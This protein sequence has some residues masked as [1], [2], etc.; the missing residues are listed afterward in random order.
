GFGN[1]MPS[2]S[3]AEI[4]ELV[5]ELGQA[6]AAVDELLLATGPGR[7][8]RRID[9]EV[10]RVAFLAIGRAGLVLGAGGHHDLDGVIVR[11]DFFSHDEI[12]ASGGARLAPATCGDVTHAFNLKAVPSDATASKRSAGPIHQPKF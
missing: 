1:E 12:P 5:L 11:M 9:V 6:A 7:M 4:G 8:G 2:G 10:Q 3:D